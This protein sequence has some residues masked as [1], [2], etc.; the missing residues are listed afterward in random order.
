MEEEGE[1][2]ILMENMQYALKEVQAFNFYSNLIHQIQDKPGTISDIFRDINSSCVIP[3]VIYGL[4]RIQY[5]YAARF[6]LTMALLLREVPGL[7]INH[8]IIICCDDC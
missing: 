6:Q 4:G 7:K 5:S 3:M 8:E 2:A 1:Y